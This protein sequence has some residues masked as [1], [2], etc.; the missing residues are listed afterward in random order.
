[1]KAKLLVLVAVVGLVAAACS[2]SGDDGVAV[3]SLETTEVGVADAVDGDVDPV[4]A[5]PVDAEQ[6][7]LAFAACMREAGVDIEDPTVDADGNVQ[8]GGIRRPALESGE[9][10][11]EEL[12]AAMSACQEDLEGVALG[13]GGRADVDQT[14]L[15]D[16]LVE[17]A[18]CMRT[19]G[20]DMDDPDYSGT[21][22]GSEEPG[23]GGGGPFGQIDRTDPDFVS[24]QEV[25]E[26]ILG[27]LPGRAGG[28]GPGA[29]G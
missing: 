5:D 22:P 12:T 6:A 26:D 14:E 24:A 25:C 3:A 4:A 17:Y 11:R 18:A 10:D 19:N 13:I 21:G 28:R 29:N 9:I 16:T 2:G 15:Q 1:M 20:Y 23:E 27:G 7:M 8:F